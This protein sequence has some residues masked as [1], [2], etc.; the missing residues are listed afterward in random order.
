[1]LVF[2]ESKGERFHIGPM[3]SQLRAVHMHWSVEITCVLSGTCAMQIDGTPYTLSAGDIAITFPLVSHGFDAF[4]E[5][6]DGFTATFLPDTIA[7]FTQT[8]HTLLPNAPLIPGFAL[9]GEIRGMID[10]L[11]AVPMGQADPYRLAYLHLLLAHLLHRLDFHAAGPGRERPLAA[12]TI[13]YVYEHAC[14]DISLDSVAHALGISKSHLSH[15]FSSRFHINFRRLVNTVRIG[16]AAALMH[17]PTANLTQIC[18]DCGYENMRTFRRAFVQE[19]GQLPSDYLRQI[20]SFA[21]GG[22]QQNPPA[23]SQGSVRSNI[24]G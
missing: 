9:D 24:I 4:S 13:Q 7:E 15:L 14:E 23:H 10:H 5:D 17:D 20:R 18:Y 3:A 2:F 6:C 19:I 8:F 21:D 11:R 1:M 22:A 16:K 12:Q